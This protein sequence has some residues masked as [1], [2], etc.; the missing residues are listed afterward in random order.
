MSTKQ[1]F[2]DE[3]NLLKRKADAKEE[4]MLPVKNSHKGGKESTTPEDP[5]R[6]I[7]PNDE[8]AS[9]WL[10]NFNFDRPSRRTVRTLHTV[11]VSLFIFSNVIKNCKS[12]I[13]TRR[14]RRAITQIRYF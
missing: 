5:R 4:S 13:Y 7:R 14:L 6:G 12:I 8:E 1:P 11:Q 3:T 9:L 2:A 10:L